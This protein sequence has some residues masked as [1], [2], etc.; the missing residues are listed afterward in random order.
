MR[1]YLQYF[2]ACMQIALR[3]LLQIA[4]NWAG[5]VGVAVVGAVGAV[6]QYGQFQELVPYPGWPGV[7]A[8]ALIRHMAGVFPLSS[9]LRGPLSAL[10]EVPAPPGFRAAQRILCGGRTTHWTQA[11]E[12]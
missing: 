4:T 2:R 1:E 3:G 12:G 7:V 9:N 11:S 10:P 6:L 8:A 5:V